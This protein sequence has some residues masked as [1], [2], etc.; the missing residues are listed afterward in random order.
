[1]NTAVSSIGTVLG[2]MLLVAGLSSCAKPEQKPTAKITDTLPNILVSVNGVNIERAAVLQRLEQ[3]KSMVA[4]QQHMARMDQAASQGGGQAKDAQAPTGGQSAASSSPT[5]HD[6]SHSQP[7]VDDKTMIR[8]LI[9]QMVM[10]QL[11]MQEVARLGLSVSPQLLEANVKHI[12]EQAGSKESLE[13]QLRQGHATVDQWRSQLKEALLLQQLAEQRRKA[14]PVSDE[15]VR[16]YWDQ[17][18][19]NLSKIWKTTRYEQAQ[20]RIRDLIQ[21]YR[22]PQTE[23]EWHNELIR[24]AK[25]WV[26]PAVREQLAS[27]ADHSHPGQGNPA[28]GNTATPEAGRRG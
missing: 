23:A 6:P 4:H 21:Q 19:E 3:T 8:N 9:N 16:K 20:D 22:W 2:A 1:M 18:R 26:D 17:N 10:E 13:D 15:E 11:K 12:E 27:P 24:N 7:D 28:Q 25:I 5:V 14:V